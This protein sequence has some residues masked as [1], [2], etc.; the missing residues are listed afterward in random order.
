MGV[1]KHLAATPVFGIRWSFSERRRAACLPSISPLFSERL[2][3]RPIGSVAAADPGRHGSVKPNEGVSNEAA[4]AAVMHA[5][6]WLKLIVEVA[7]AAMI[8]AG[9]S[10][11]HGYLGQ[12]NS[13][14]EQGCLR[15]STTAVCPVPAD[16]ASSFSWVRIAVIRTA[17]NFFLQRE[18]REGHS[19]DG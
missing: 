1:R 6:L 4:G 12:R 9:I 18:L 15:R 8:G 16:G 3:Y 17:L 14:V 5:V 10:G 13:E 11:G 7:G 2:T 19:P